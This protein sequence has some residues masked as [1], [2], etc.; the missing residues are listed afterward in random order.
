MTS[1][2]AMF[3]KKKKQ[4]QKN[5]K[6]FVR[7]LFPRNPDDDINLGG[8]LH[9]KHPCSIAIKETFHKDCYQESLVKFGL[10]PQPI[11]DDDEK[12]YYNHI[13][14]VNKEIWIWYH[15]N[16][17]S[18][19]YME[20]IYEFLDEYL[21]N[22]IRKALLLST[23]RGTTLDKMI[24]VFG[25]ASYGLFINKLSD[26]DIGVNL[27]I[28]ESNK[29]KQSLSNPHKKKK[30][31]RVRFLKMLSNKIR[32]NN[33]DVW[34]K[35]NKRKQKDKPN[36]SKQPKPKKKKKNNRHRKMKKWE[37]KVLHGH[38]GKRDVIVREERFDARVPILKLYVPKYKL[39][40]DIS[41][42]SSSNF[43]SKLIML[44]VKYDVRVRPFLCCIKY[45]VAQRSICEAYKGY[46]NTFGWILLGIKFLQNGLEIPILPFM[47]MDVK[48]GK[49][50]INKANLNEGEGK[51]NMDTV[52][53]LLS[54]FFE[55]YAN[56]NFGL[57]Q[58]SIT[59]NIA[60]EPK[61]TRSMQVKPHQRV[62]VIQH[63]LKEHINVS[64]S[65][66]RWTSHFMK[67]QLS[68]AA[69]AILS[70]KWRDVTK[71]ISQP[72][73]TQA[74]DPNY[75]F[76]C[77]LLR[78]LRYDV[79]KKQIIQFVKRVAN[80]VSVVMAQYNSGR[81]VGKAY[82]ALDTPQ[83]AHCVMAE[84]N[85]NLL[86]GRPVIMLF[87][88]IEAMQDEN[89]AVDGA[90]DNDVD[91]KPIHLGRRFRLIGNENDDNVEET[92][93]IN[94]TE[95]EEESEQ[96]DDDEMILY[97]EPPMVHKGLLLD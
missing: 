63:P 17:P 76:S 88:S 91:M 33:V 55:Y 22:M 48:S 10:D 25:S 4:R 96:N 7:I 23:G 5:K 47:K 44:Y 58:I 36:V 19:E 28:K 56:F 65:V 2:A 20:K 21:L 97:D 89:G 43:V 59:K 61:D 53:E 74:V 41:V 87:T 79:T 52:A 70:S 26:I 94:D 31:K 1:V 71:K 50:M 75:E 16:I 3:N 13:R 60:L 95:E 27:C 8:L 12:L 57:Y 40:L 80:P 45:W 83:V 51:K 77:L 38:K 39:P 24:T 82:V 92:E 15:Q 34:Q 72:S 42:G 66:K 67:Q 9:S 68:V 49:V 14:D 18:G 90:N 29:K 37:M 6:E 62:W 93:Q 85:G 30:S 81:H 46:L 35:I 73:Q 11:A 54:S 84:L 78:N 69:D 86:L 32:G 64:S